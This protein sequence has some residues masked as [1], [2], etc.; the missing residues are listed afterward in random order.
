MFRN[1]LLGISF[2][3]IFQNPGLAREGS[4]I[5]SS[6]DTLLAGQYIMAAE[7][8]LAR[9][10]YDSAVYY[11]ELAAKLYGRKKYLVNYLKCQNSII[12][13][14]R[15]SG[16]MSGLLKTASGNL[17]ISLAKFGES[18]AITGDCFN[19]I[20]ELYSTANNQDSALFF[21]R[22]ALSVMRKISNHDS[23]KL[24]GTYRNL[25]VVCIDKGLF[26]SASFY[27]GKSTQVLADVYGDNDPEL[28]R[29]FNLSGSIAYYLGRLDECE[30]YF[31]KTVRI[32]ENSSGIN[33]P[34]TAE[35]YNN[36]AVLYYARGMFDTALVLNMKA[37]KI[38]QLK[39]HQDHPNIALSLNNIGNIYLET[40]KYELAAYYHKMA[41]EIRN[42]IYKTENADIAMSYANLGVLNFKMGQ[43]NEALD[44][45][46]KYLKIT[47]KIFGEENPHT[48]DAYNNVGSAFA[49]LGDYKESLFYHRK[50]LEMRLKR[51]RYSPGVPTSYKNIGLIYKF[52]GDYDLSLSY[53]RRSVDAVLH[54]NGINHPDLIDLYSNIGEIHSYLGR[55]DSA[56]YYLNKSIGLCI[57]E[58]G[59][60]NT[61]LI[62]GY[63]NRGNLLCKLN[64]PQS[65]ILD[66]RK[67]LEVA[68]KAYGEYHP[69][70]SELYKAI[71]GV[72]LSRGKIDSSFFYQRRALKIKEKC[73]AGP[74]PALVSGYREMGELYQ[75]MGKTDSARFFHI[76]SLEAGYTQPFQTEEINAS[77]ILDQYEFALTVFNLCRLDYNEYLISGNQ[78]LLVEIIRLYDYVKIFVNTVIS[79]YILEETKIRLLNQLSKHTGIA[80]EAAFEMYRRTA[81]P[82]YF[83]KA[84][85]F[86]ELHKSSVIR[87]L[88]QKYGST[89]GNNIYARLVLRKKNLLGQIDYLQIKLVKPDPLTD[90]KYKREIQTKIDSLMLNL[91]ELSD[92]LNNFTAG[93]PPGNQKNSTPLNQTLKRRIKDNESLVSYYMSDSAL[94]VFVI[95]PDTSLLIRNE[96]YNRENLKALIHDYLSA[97]KKYEK[98][99]LPELSFTLYKALFGD[100]RKVIESSDKLILIPDKDLFL[101]PFETLT[102]KYEQVDEFSDFAK[103]DFIINHFNLV[104]HYSSEL[105][106]S[107]KSCGPSPANG[108]LAFAPVF[109]NKKENTIFS[110]NEGSSKGPPGNDQSY[111]FTGSRMYLREL[112]YSL[113]ETDSL[114][115]LFES[116]GISTRI[117]THDNATEE[118]F[119]QNIG[120]YRFVHI[121]THGIFDN[122]N[123]E[124]SGLVFTPD[125]KNVVTDTL[126]GYTEDG[127][128]YAKDL[129]PLDINADLVTLSACETGKGKLEEGEGF[130]GLLRGFISAGAS[131]VLFSYWRVD[132]KSTLLFMNSFYRFLLN[133]NNYSTALRNSKINLIKDPETS[134][135]LLWGSFALIG[136]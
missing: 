92:S 127:V 112:P 56:L 66:F 52:H 42:R 108:L 44:H 45:F 107:E 28:A 5:N 18:S 91:R 26:D 51:G 99:R 70:I 119:K 130:I 14:K 27:I 133:E 132:D 59:T 33:H 19:I 22:K 118:N 103:Q 72:M 81:D 88:V 80:V 83:N 129:Y 2:L 125:R 3:I 116:R 82:E 123:P 134:Y 101:L 115:H 40:S 117:F 97:M 67:G 46:I 1:L 34:L 53:L 100:L 21:F 110:Q 87:N 63:L 95:A 74:H 38:R 62:S 36:L 90:L 30:E 77:L 16:K 98:E 104:Y 60:E 39:L 10:A 109:I 49:D 31:Q 71:S 8:L 41:L 65:G 79:D 126:P 58:L 7:K 15:S 12:S 122:N 11:Y 76:R 93:N 37:L 84:F 111:L 78:D 96:K 29:N 13:A 20:G 94:F 85:E 4:Y 128:L 113:A 121:A 32:R 6:K 43:Y 25:G 64:D 54:L 105:W 120:K 48:S 9:A 89:E 35:A 75:M 23:K 55:S 68:K 47:E 69:Q 50:A 102:G 136:R 131:N 57:S 73:F 106:S 124:Y 114:K 24:A 17:Q 86:S 135:P 61:R